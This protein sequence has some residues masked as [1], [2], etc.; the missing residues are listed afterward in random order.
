MVPRVRLTALRESRLGK[1]W[2]VTNLAATSKVGLRLVCDADDGLPITLGTARKL[3]AAFDLPVA[4]LA[5]QETLFGDDLKG[6]VSPGCHVAISQ[7]GDPESCEWARALHQEC[8]RQIE[9]VTANGVSLGNLQSHCVCP[10][11]DL[12]SQDGSR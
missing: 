2:T 9:A 7:W 3:A 11:H 8:Q 1:G 10:C 6:G 5:G 4:V 12:E